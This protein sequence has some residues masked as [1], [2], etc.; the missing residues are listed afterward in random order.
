MFLCVASEWFHLRCGFAK[1]HLVCAACA[2]RCLTVNKADSNKQDTLLNVTGC[3]T[4]P[5]FITPI[6]RFL[7][8]LPVLF[9]FSLASSQRQQC[10]DCKTLPLHRLHTCTCVASHSKQFRRC[11]QTAVNQRRQRCNEAGDSFCTPVVVHSIKPRGVE[12]PVC[13]KVLQVKPDDTVSH[14]TLWHL[15]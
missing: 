12:L 5:R 8:C 2:P 11:R 6:Q 1:N 14:K 10:N 15:V 4:P 7:S 9:V 13:A 3:F